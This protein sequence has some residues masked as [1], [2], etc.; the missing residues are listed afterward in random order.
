MSELMRKP[1]AIEK[2]KRFTFLGFESAGLFSLF[3]VSPWVGIPL[4]GIGA[5][6]GWDWFKFRVKNGMR[7]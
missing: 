2:K 1:T 6:F 7:F 3:F 5:Y 4:M